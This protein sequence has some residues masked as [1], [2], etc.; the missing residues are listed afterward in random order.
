MVHNL[1]RRD[2]LPRVEAR[3]LYTACRGRRALH[4]RR[5]TLRTRRKAPLYALGFPYFC[6]PR[7][8]RAL[9]LHN[10]LCVVSRNGNELYPRPSGDLQMNCDSETGRGGKNRRGRFA[11]LRAERG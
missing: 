8:P 1:C 6:H 11:A 7:Q 5:D 4:V 2:D 10:F 9:L 3:G